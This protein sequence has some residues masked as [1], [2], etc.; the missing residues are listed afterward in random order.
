MQAGNAQM[1]VEIL[2]NIMNIFVFIYLI[3]RF[4]FGWSSAVG[5]V[6]LMECLRSDAVGQ[7]RKLEE[8]TSLL[9]PSHELLRQL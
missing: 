4:K 6:K 5:P 7:V 8:R 9:E 2:P 1:P 3:S